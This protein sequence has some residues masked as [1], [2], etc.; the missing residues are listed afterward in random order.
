MESIFRYL[1]IASA[2]ITILFIIY[3][4]FFK[5]D[6][7]FR[8][9][10]FFLLSGLLFS[11]LLPFNTYNIE[12]PEFSDQA[13][14]FVE[15]RKNNTSG[16][17]V[18]NLQ[19]VN[20]DKSRPVET[21]TGQQTSTPINSNQFILIIYL[22]IS[23]ILIVR[24][25]FSIGQI[26]WYYLVSDKQKEQGFTVVY[27]TKRSIPF[28]FF[29][30]IFITKED[31]NKNIQQIIEHEKIHAKQIHTIDLLIAELLVAA[32]WFNPFIWMYK[33]E[34]QQVHEFLADEGVLNSGA[35][36][37]E[38]QALLVNQAAEGRLVALSS[39]FSYSLIKK[40]L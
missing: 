17:S 8:L 22:I 14:T 26:G 34:L 15:E 3:L 27:I 12:L 2:S 5:K 9:S 32:M 29:R 20:T 40:E 10:R 28:S 11:L 36:Q 7:N 4:I 21:A 24:I 30:L 16:E 25:L 19:P 13:E 38:Y 6:N 31:L 39:N 35:D 33:R 23:S 1:I 37:L 18:I